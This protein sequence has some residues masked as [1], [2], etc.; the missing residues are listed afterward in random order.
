MNDSGSRREAT[1]PRPRLATRRILR[2]L[3]FWAWLVALVGIPYATGLLAR[4][5]SQAIVCIS[6]LLLVWGAWLARIRVEEALSSGTTGAGRA[7]FRGSRAAIV[8]MVAISLTDLIFGVPYFA[9]RLRAVAGPADS[10]PVSVSLG[11]IIQAIDQ[12][13][14]AP[15][16][17]TELLQKGAIGLSD[18]RPSGMSIRPMPDELQSLQKKLRFGGLGLTAE[19][20][21]YSIFHYVRDGGALVIVS[22]PVRDI[23]FGRVRLMGF[24]SG[25][26]IE[27]V[28]SESAELSAQ[29]VTR[30]W[31]RHLLAKGEAWREAIPLSHFKLVVSGGR[32]AG[33][34][35]RVEFFDIHPA[36]R[37]P[38]I[39]IHRGLRRLDASLSPMV[40]GGS[41]RYWVGRVQ[42]P[43][44]KPISAYEG[45]MERLKRFAAGQLN[46]QRLCA[47]R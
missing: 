26:V 38:P 28:A 39:V 11:R 42:V 33:F 32:P 17:L 6:L 37:R 21:R 19:I 7:S 31:W 4:T 10:S 47:P 30:P 3:I 43:L 9:A 27:S 46:W 35:G 25:L 1:V 23:R 41:V 12:S 40:S 34:R 22:R 14:S 8:A 15:D 18:L 16:G 13:A 20:K 36:G 2:L 24:R 45:L 44:L 5:E 29:K